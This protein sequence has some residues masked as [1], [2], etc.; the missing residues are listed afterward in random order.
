[1]LG[2]DISLNVKHSQLCMIFLV[3]IAQRNE[4][5]VANRTAAAAFCLNEAGRQSMN[6][7]AKVALAEVLRFLE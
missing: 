5:D 2:L 6:E 3:Y 1:M 7:G 4:C